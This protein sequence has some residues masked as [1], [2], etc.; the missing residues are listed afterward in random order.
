MCHEAVASP[1]VCE[2]TG[3]IVLASRSHVRGQSSSRRIKTCDCCSKFSLVIVCENPELGLNVRNCLGIFCCSRGLCDRVQHEFTGVGAQGEVL[4][5]SSTQSQR[6][7]LPTWLGL[8]EYLREASSASLST[9]WPGANSPTKLFSGSV[10]YWLSNLD[11]DQ[12]FDCANIA[13]RQKA[14]LRTFRSWKNCISGVK[15]MDYRCDD[16]CFPVSASWL[17]MPTALRFPAV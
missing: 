12:P 2:E 3:L 11:S 13:D 15:T 7:V 1:F 4:L 14:S 10:F 6:A 16:G 17:A 5:V 8:W 9:T